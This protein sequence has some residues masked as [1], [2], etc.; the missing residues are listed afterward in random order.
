MRREGAGGAGSSPGMGAPQ[1]A[2][3]HPFSAPVPT[4]EPLV[5]SADYKLG[6]ALAQ[7]I[8]KA[9]PTRDGWTVHSALP[10]DLGCL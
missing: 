7:L 4:G 10:S 9:K 1:Q 6:Q 3:R 5:D 8:N 2:G